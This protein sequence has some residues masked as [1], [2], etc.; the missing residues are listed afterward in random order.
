MLHCHCC[1]TVYIVGQGEKLERTPPK[2][3]NGTPYG[4]S[5]PVRL[6]DLVKLHQGVSESAHDDETILNNKVG[7]QR[8]KAEIGWMN[9]QI[10]AEAV[11]QLKW[12]FEGVRM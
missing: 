4:R 5:R 1:Q 9:S 6:L 2:D 7:L 11:H 3:E 10:Y 8:V 12:H